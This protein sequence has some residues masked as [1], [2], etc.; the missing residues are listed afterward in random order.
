MGYKYCPY[1]EVSDTLV[2]REKWYCML[3][4]EYVSHSTYQKYCYCSGYNDYLECPKYKHED[5]RRREKGLSELIR[6]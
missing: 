4:E 1:M 2:E 3:R 6:R 5:K